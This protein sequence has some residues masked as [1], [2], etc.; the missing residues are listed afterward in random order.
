MP[1]EPTA[2]CRARSDKNASRRAR[3]GVTRP[4]GLT[5][6][7]ELLPPTDARG[8]PLS[9]ER[10]KW[11]LQRRLL[12]EGLSP[13]DLALVSATLDLSPGGQFTTAA[14]AT[15]AKRAGMGRS[16][17][18]KTRRKLLDRGI[19]TT[20]PQYDGDG[21]QL[22]SKH[23]ITPAVFE[24]AEVFFSGPPPSTGWTGPRPPSGHKRDP[25]CSLDP[26]SEPGSSSLSETG[27]QRARATAAP[28]P[29]FVDTVGGPAFAELQ[30]AHA[31]AHAEK[32]GREA[33]RRSEPYNPRD[34]G[35]LRLEHR[36]AVG[37]YLR[38][39]AARGHAFALA[40]FRDDLST[41]AIRRDLIAEI[42]RAFFNQERPYLREHAHPL[43]CLWGKGGT[44]PS[45][46]E[47]MLLGERALE[48]WCEALEP[49][50]SP[51][52]AA[53]LEEAARHLDALEDAE[54]RD[55]CAEL[56]ERFAAAAATGEVPAEFGPPP[57]CAS[58][59][60]PHD[61]PVTPAKPV[62][63]SPVDVRAELARIDAD[64]R[65]RA[66]A[67][68]AHRGGRAHLATR[69]RDR[70]A[71]LAALF[72]L[73]TPTA[74]LGGPEHEPPD[75]QPAPAL[76]TQAAPPLLRD[77]RKRPVRRTPKRRRAPPRL[78]PSLR[79]WK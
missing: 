23:A 25:L 59:D 16:T 63:P 52:L 13:F 24:R 57:D 69:P 5:P 22:T 7:P 17:A 41:D 1:I 74:A 14:M 77:A 40:R 48:A 67:R 56:R 60:E 73:A 46:C 4:K 75:E 33:Q 35:T 65:A 53:T 79:G 42:V 21:S 27:N 58:D 64:A 44:D 68:R 9:H 36:G 32:Y 29:V 45:R 66:K 49:G 38:N 18:F 37:D 61:E 26:S 31:K 6:P 62:P 51:D 76:W 47:L 54:A 28:P 20:E 3:P 72:A 50:R 2:A 70:F 15:I 34:A 55:A 71:L 10:V 78:R 19:L 11:K 12:Q 43:G 30:A 39:L 8:R